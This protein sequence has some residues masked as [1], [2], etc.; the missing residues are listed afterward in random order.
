MMLPQNAKICEA[1]KPQTGAAARSGDWVSLK[2]YN[3]CMIIVHI[4]QGNAAT[5]AITVDKATD[6]AGTGESTGIT[7]NNWWYCKDTP[8]TSDTY[9]KGT[10]AASI[11]SSATGTG[12]SI[13]V[14][15]IAAEELG[16]YDC[17]Q[18]ELGQSHASNL[19]SAMYVLYEPR[20]ADSTMPV[21]AIAD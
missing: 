11:T 4:A 3:K 19:V 20:Y 21:S 13:Y 7:M 14:I 1:I 6:V 12:S 15:D 16:A 17:V 5:T 10:A 2:G 18:V 9:T 8:T